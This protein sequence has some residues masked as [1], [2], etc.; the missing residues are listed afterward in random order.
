MPAVEPY[1]VQFPKPKPNYPGGIQ[2]GN[3]G[4]KPTPFSRP[5]G[6]KPV[7][8]V[9]ISDIHVDRHYDV[10]SSYKCDYDLCCHPYTSDEAPGKTEY[11]AGP[12][13][14]TNCDSPLSLEESMYAAVKQF[15]PNAEFTLFTGDLVAG[16]EWST[17]VPGVTAEMNDVFNNR[18]PELGLV[19]PA[20]GN[21]DTNPVNMFPPPSVPAS[22]DY[23]WVYDTLASDWTKWIGSENAHTVR[24]NHGSYSVLHNNRLRIIS[25]N[26][27]FWM[28]VNFWMYTPIMARD[29]TGML[30]WLAD[31]L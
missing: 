16:V 21:H 29:P 24:S 30:A 12:Y 1:T 28:E 27:M 23:T 26:T 15:A 6:E 9:H 8:I 11:P 7:E 14:N 5:H 22:N 31:E 10:G 18:M 4:G 25:L 19:Y 3:P 13:E 20:V 2:G 17:T